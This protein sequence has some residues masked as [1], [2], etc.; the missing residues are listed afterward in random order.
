MSELLDIISPSGV[1]TILLAILSGAGGSALLDLYWK[2]RRDRRRAAALLHADIVMNMQLIQFHS[3][4]RKNAPRTIPMDLKLSRLGFDTAG[5]I[6]SELP[7]ELL[8]PVVLLYSR[9]DDLN[10]NVDLYAEGIDQLGTLTSTLQRAKQQHYLNS[11]V[12]V[13]NTGMDKARETCI[14]VGG[15]IEKLAQVRVDRNQPKREFADEAATLLRERK[16]RID[17]LAAMDDEESAPGG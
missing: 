14:E 1:G 16:Q 7:T 10:R 12:D 2:P 8:R 17:A 11:I 4:L 6:I 9:I 5:N 15:R 13:F 3:H